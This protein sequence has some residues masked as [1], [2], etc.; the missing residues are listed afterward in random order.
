LDLTP[1]KKEDRSWIR[2]TIGREDEMEEALRFF[3]SL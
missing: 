3:A 1:P 2:L